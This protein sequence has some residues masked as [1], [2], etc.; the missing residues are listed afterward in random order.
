VAR[1]D[2]AEYGVG[3]SSAVGF[4][5]VL[6]LASSRRLQFQRW[7]KTYS[8]LENTLIAPVC[9]HSFLHFRLGGLWVHDPVLSCNLLAV[10]PLVVGLFLSIFLQLLCETGLELSNLCILDSVALAPRSIGFQIFDLVLDAG[11]EHLRLRHHALERIRSTR[12]VGAGYRLLVEGRDLANVGRESP[13]IG[14]DGF[15]AREEVG[16]REGV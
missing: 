8:C 14:L 9:V 13:D 16:V 3:S 4:E 7:Q 15:D 11:V 2:I 1:A 5:L 10:P 12:I 6:E